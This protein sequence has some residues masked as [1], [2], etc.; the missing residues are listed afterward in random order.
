M[1]PQPPPPNPV[2]GRD[3]MLPLQ[4]KVWD[5]GPVTEDKLERRI[6]VTFRGQ[7]WCFR[8]QLSH[9]ELETIRG[10]Q[11]EHRTKF[12]SYWNDSFVLQAFRGFYDGVL[13]RP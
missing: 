7:V 4:F 6:E 13:N 9:V 10:N 11:E 5:S 1:T 3:R 2:Y 12:L 8:K